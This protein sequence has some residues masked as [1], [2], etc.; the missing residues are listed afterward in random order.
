MHTKNSL[1]NIKRDDILFAKQPYNSK[2]EAV[3]ALQE[4]HLRPGELAAVRYYTSNLKMRM[5]IGCGGIDPEMNKN[6]FIFEDNSSSFEIIMPDGTI[7][8]TNGI[9]ETVEIILQNLNTINNLD[10]TSFVT[11]DELKTEIDYIYANI[12]ADIE[13]IIEEQNIPL[14]I[15]NAIEDAIKNIDFTNIDGEEI[16]EE[17]HLSE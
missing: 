10:I 12:E 15:E 7:K 17:W 11:K 6:V 14:K 16:K 5:L 4:R 13:R 2:S 1:K 3:V 8:N 9:D